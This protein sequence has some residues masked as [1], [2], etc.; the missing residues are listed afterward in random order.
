MKEPIN[1]NNHYNN[2]NNKIFCKIIKNIINITQRN[3]TIRAC[4]LKFIDK[5][6]N[7]RLKFCNKKTLI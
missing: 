2:T 6:K 7:K 4:T 5:G 1:L 3:S